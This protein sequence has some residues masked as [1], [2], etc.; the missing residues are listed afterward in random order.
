MRELFFG[1]GEWL[2]SKTHLFGQDRQMGSFI[3]DAAMDGIANSIPGGVNLSNR[4]ELGGLMGVSPYGGFDWK[5]MMGPAG[6]LMS[7]LLVK[8]PQKASQG[9][10]WGAAREA[11]PNNQVRR[12]AQLAADGFNIRNKDERLNVE[13]NASEKVLMAAGFTPKKVTDFRA[14]DEMKRR[15]EK[16]HSQEQ[17][18]F[19]ENM[20][21]LAVQGTQAL[22]QRARSVANYDPREGARRV[23][24]L[25]Q[26]RTEPFD[27]TRTGSKVGKTYTVGRLYP[28]GEQSP[29]ETQRLLQR[30]G[31]TQQLGFPQ[32]LTR[33]EIR[34][35]ELL[36][37]LMS[38]YPQMTRVEAKAMLDKQ[39]HPER[40]VMSGMAF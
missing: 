26:S 12:I 36:V 32:K 10:V 29:P 40:M 33:T 6:D 30:W 27:P 38:M 13:L 17:K 24:E 15:A 2:N 25:V 18:T 37:Q 21:S 5:N 9:D 34:E 8:V 4:F 19:H 16:V 39:L 1:T 3:A 35:A 7:R 31:L 23:A 22:W 11:I 14:L 28:H 20:A